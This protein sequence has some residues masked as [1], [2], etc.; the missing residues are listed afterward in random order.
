MSLI[1]RHGVKLM[2]IEPD[3]LKPTFDLDRP[4]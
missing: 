1:P 4:T 3:N 2:W